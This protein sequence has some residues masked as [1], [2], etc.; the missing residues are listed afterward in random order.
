MKDNL[1]W[2]DLEMTGLDPERHV[3]IEIAALAT[4]R[5]L[6]IL[7]EGPEM[8]IGHSEGVL[9]GMEPWSR[10][11]HQASGLLDRV[12]SSSHDMKAAEKAVLDFVRQY[13]Y[14]GQAPLCGNSIWQDRRFL[15]AHMPELEAFFH[16]RNVDVSSIKELVRRWYPSLAPFEKKKDHRALK[17]ITESIAELRYYREQVFTGQRG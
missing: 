13:A 16:Y 10:E 14:P 3:I 9:S 1:I 7:A 2:V 8:V 5:D 11:H 17:D 6:N 15:V 4:D 12:R